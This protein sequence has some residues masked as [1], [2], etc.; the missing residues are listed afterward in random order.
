[1][2]LLRN[3]KVDSIKAIAEKAV[4][5]IYQAQ[6]ST[7]WVVRLGDGTEE[8]HA[9]IQKSIDNLWMWSE[10]SLKTIGL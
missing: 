1:M 4:K 2:I 3:C 9:K 7:E 10:S 5:E 6:W 8:S